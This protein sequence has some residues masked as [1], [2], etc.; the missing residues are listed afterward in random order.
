M[1]RGR[2][3]NPMKSFSVYFLAGLSAAS[4]AVACDLCAVYNASAAHGEVEKGFFAGV[5]EQFTYFGTLQ[6]NGHEIRDPASQKLES[7]ITQ[8]YAGYNVNSRF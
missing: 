4:P 5:A 7:S 8:V 1:A 3:F 2:L 6:D